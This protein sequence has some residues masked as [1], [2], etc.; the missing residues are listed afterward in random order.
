[1][2]LLRTLSLADSDLQNGNR[3]LEFLCLSDVSTG[4]SLQVVSLALDGGLVR[5]LFFLEC[6]QQPDSKLDVGDS[7]NTSFSSFDVSLGNSHSESDDLGL[8]LIARVELDSSEQD[9]LFE[10]EQ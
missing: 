1:M 3:V 5:F 4:L 9:L 10:V 8:P 6:S 2:G 7:S